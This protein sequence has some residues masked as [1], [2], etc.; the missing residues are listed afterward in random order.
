MR[1]LQLLQINSK[2]SKLILG[3]SSVSRVK[4]LESIGYKPDIIAHPEI[5]ETP[6]KNELPRQ[7]ALRLAEAKAAKVA[8]SYPHDVVISADT[9]CAVGRLQLPK[10]LCEEDVRFCLKK[11]SGKRHRTYT[12]ICGMHNGRIISK[13]SMTVVEFKVLNE[14]DIEEFVFDKKQWYGKA[15]G[16]TLMGLAA[17]FVVMMRGDQESAV[18]GLPLY[19]ARNIIKTL[20][21]NKIHRII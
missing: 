9:I 19:H 2:V 13:L 16:Y 14:S 12:G 8:E 20:G 10:A 5:D 1:K 21:Q 3:S 7:T 17:A 11:L 4:L 15:G 18:L 6:L